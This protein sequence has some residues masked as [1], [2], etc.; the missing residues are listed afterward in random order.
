M[1][2]AQL[3]GRR[4]LL[5]VT[6][7][8]AAY[9]AAMLAR[10]LVQAGATVDTVLTRA[11]REFIGP[12]T[13]EGITGRPCRSSVFDFTPTASQAHADGID[14]ETHVALSRAA[15]AI[16]VYPAT[17]HLLAKAAHGLA[18][19]L[20]TTSLLAATCPVILAP[21]MHT[22]M[23]EDPATQANAALLSSRG[24]RL[25]GPATGPLMGGDEGPGRVVEPDE[26]LAAVTAAIGPGDLAGLTIVV[27]AGGT[28]EPLDPVRFLGNRSTGKMGFAIADQAARR[29]A[30]THLVAAPSPL[31]TPPGVERHDVVTA[32]EMHKRVLE[33]AT[34]AD[35]II[36]AAAVADFRPSSAAEH[37]VKKAAGTPLV[38]LV[39]NPDILADLG[40]EKRASGRT[41]P[42]LVGFAAET[43]HAE[44]AGREKLERKGA[45]LLV[46]N[47]VSRDDAGFGVDTNHVVILGADGMR[48]EVP[49]T[50]K[51]AVADV[52]LDEVVA[53]LD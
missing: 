13:F 51:H 52:L 18:D 49:L 33:L 1:T 4:I 44:E 11:A 42:I 5:G 8:I 27:T 50:R 53:R 14:E 37:K 47:D 21:A 17:A 20:L 30:L 24:Y 45:D 28:R 31:F 23:W 40:A 22:E 2:G 36:K 46:V 26:A 39:P 29:G 48:R 38:E 7:G 15:D 16:L 32:L 10:L 9:K 43:Q 19:D 12:A 25:V 41:R 35:V 6:G 3:R 34:D